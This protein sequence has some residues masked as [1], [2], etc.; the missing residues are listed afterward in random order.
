MLCLAVAWVYCPGLL[1]ECTVVDTVCL[2]KT[3]TRDCRHGRGDTWTTVNQS[4]GP[5]PV[6]GGG[7]RLGERWGGEETR[8]RYEEYTN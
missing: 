1:S 4:S 6:S 8:M 7:G 3:H 2:M 5:F